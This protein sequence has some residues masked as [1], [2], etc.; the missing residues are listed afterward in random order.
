MVQNMACTRLEVTSFVLLVSQMHYM[1][2]TVAV[3]GPIRHPSGYTS[4][5]R[6]LRA[7]Q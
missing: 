7:R 1:H 5:G 2:G 4:A 6:P 3:Q